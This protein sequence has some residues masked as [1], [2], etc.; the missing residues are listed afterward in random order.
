ME[1]RFLNNKIGIREQKWHTELNSNFSVNFWDKSRKLCASINHENPIKWLQHQIVR[2]SLQ[3]NL[4]VSHFIQNVSPE[5]QYCQNTPETI[6]HLFYLCPIVKQFLNDI[7]ALVSS[8]GLQFTPTRDQFLFGYLD[9][10]FNTPSNY[11]VLH[12][13]KF[14]WN[15]K[16]KTPINLSMV[17]FKNYFKNILFDLKLI[18]ELKNKSAEFHVWNDLLALLPAGDH[19][20]QPPPQLHDGQ[21]PA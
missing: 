12:L 2:N 3:T 16:F 10:T 14:I 8:T 11:L 20:V 9:Q 13:K 18:Y 17:G 7:F 6:S 1:K 4:I 15:A 21:L 5:C 19:L